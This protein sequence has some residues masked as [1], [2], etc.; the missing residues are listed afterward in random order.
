MPFEK[1][2]TL[3]VRL[4]AAP[5]K[6]PEISTWLV[7]A[8]LSARFELASDAV[9]V[10]ISAV[11]RTVL[12]ASTLFIARPAVEVSV[13]LAS[14]VVRS[15]PSAA[16]D[17]IECADEKSNPIADVD[18]RTVAVCVLALSVDWMTDWLPVIPL[19]RAA[20]PLTA[21]AVAGLVA[22]VVLNT[23]SVRLL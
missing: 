20:V 5:V 16:D 9:A 19:R 1:L 2:V 4:V 22:I 7:D 18:E 8:P 3:T 12:A 21:A 17:S 10:F 14:G 15:R 11:E 13:E 23:G 6:A